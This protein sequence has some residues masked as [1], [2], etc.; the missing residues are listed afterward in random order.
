[1]PN[2]VVMFVIKCENYRNVQNM[3]GITHLGYARAWVRLCLEKKLLC[4][5]L[6]TL[7][8]EES[9]L[10]YVYHLKLYCYDKFSNNFLFFSEICI[11]ATLSCVI[12]M[13]EMSF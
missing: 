11:H 4:E 10:R 8:S 7:L 13:S 1:M 6:T 2:Q 9:L 12:K 5:H 3:T